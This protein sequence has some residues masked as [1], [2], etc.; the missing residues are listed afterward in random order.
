MVVTEH[1]TTPMNLYIKFK[2]LQVTSFVRVAYMYSAV[3]SPFDIN[4][5]WRLFHSLFCVKPIYGAQGYLT[6]SGTALSQ[7][8]FRPW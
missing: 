5:P 7:Y 4:F 1:I 3:L 8:Q 2:K 6:C